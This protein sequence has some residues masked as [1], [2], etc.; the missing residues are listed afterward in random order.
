MRERLRRI[1]LTGR[2]GLGVLAV[3]ALLGLLAPLIS[4]AAPD[5]FVGLPL[6]PPDVHHPLGTDD[7]GHDLLT[8]LLY[9][10]RTSV[11]VGTLAA[12]LA[13]AV[14]ALVAVTAGYRG[15]VADA[16]A[17]RVVDLFLVLPRLPL[18]LLLVTLAGPSV[19]TTI[20]VIGL[21]SWPWGARILRS[22]VLSLR[23]RTHIRAAELFGARTAYVAR[24][25]LLPELGPVLA[26]QFIS[27]ARFAVFLEAGLGFLGLS[28]PS[29][30]SWGTTL[31]YALIH[32]G[33]YFGSDWVWWV[34][35][36]ALGLTLLILGCTFTGIALEERW[37]PRLALRS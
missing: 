6:Q 2:F 23:T 37:N 30:T 28:D 26:S 8:A 10:A 22:Q 29:S 36:P 4:P 34:L 7:V 20:L 16:L 33:I 3:I 24:R 14:S 15:G 35:P 13:L 5:A 11:I 31:H 12:I 17:M 9:G 18:L 25:H 1:P 32:P 21:L 19:T 27:N